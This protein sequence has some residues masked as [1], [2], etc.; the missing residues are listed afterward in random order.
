MN[1][2]LLIMLNC[3]IKYTWHWEQLFQIHCII[4]LKHNK[5]LQLKLLLFTWQTWIKGAFPVRWV[6]K[7]MYIFMDIYIL[8]NL[9]I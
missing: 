8:N 3:V 5:Y 7:N 9:V 1:Q 6:S 2:A 4:V